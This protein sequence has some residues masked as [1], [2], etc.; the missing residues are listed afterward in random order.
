MNKPAYTLT[1]FGLRQ[2]SQ[3]KLFTLG[4][5]WGRMIVILGALSLTLMLLAPAWAGDGTL[6]PSFSNP[7]V[8]KIPIVRGKV[9]YQ[10]SNGNANGNSL[11]FGYFTS[12]TG[13]NGTFAINS[14]A[15]LPSGGGV[16]ANFNIPVNGQ[17]R[18]VFLTN[19]KS[20]TSNIVLGGSFSLTSGNTTYYNL[21]RLTWDSNNSIYVVDTTFP[22]VFNQVITDAGF[23]VS[24]VNAIAKQGSTGTF[25][26]GGYN[27]QV[28]GDSSNHAYHL[29]H[30]NSSWNWD[31]TYS[32]NNPARA[33]PGGYVNS[34]NL[35]D[36]NYPNQARIFG[37]LPKVGGG[38]D[39]MELTS[40]DLST[41][42]QSLGSDQIDSSIY[43]MALVESSGPWVIW[44]NFKH[45]YGTEIHRVAMLTNDLSDLDNTSYAS[46]NSG[47][48]SGGGAN[49][50]VHHAI[51]QFPSA[52]ILAGTFTS[53]NGTACG[54]L[55]R[56]TSSGTV[57]ST[58][59]PGGSGFDDRTYKVYIPNGGSNINIVGAFR[60]YNNGSDNARHGIVVLDSNG[61]LQGNYA[62]ISA[63]SSTPGTVIAMED[64]SQGDGSLIIGGDFT[65]VGGKWH[66][67]LAKVNQD[68]STDNTY[69]ANVD[70]VVTSLRTSNGNQLVAG[71]FGAA[72]GVGRTSLARLSAD[73]SGALDNSFNPIFVKG[74]GTLPSIHVA[75]ADNSGLIIVGGHFASVNS[76]T[77]TGVVRL[78]S[79]GDLD[80]TFTFT[81]PAGL[82]DIK[83]NAGGNMGGSYPMLGR[84][85]YSGS[86]RGFGLRLLSDGTLDSSF[87]INQSPVANV[88]LFDH[89]VL[90]AGSK[91]DGTLY[92]GGKFTLVNDGSNFTIAR[93]RIARFTPNGT[94]DTSWAPNGADDTIYSVDLQPDGRILVGGLFTQFNSVPRN[95]FARLNSS[96]SVDTSLNPG[97][98]PNGPVALVSWWGNSHVYIGG[99]FSSYNGTSMESRVRII[100]HQVTPATF[101]L[102]LM[103]N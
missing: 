72:N 76:T 63:D 56:I 27:L 44:G 91:H 4:G 102:P 68:G 80:S 84:A 74:N 61:G 81:P 12:I 98:G 19:P 43:G 53:F 96:G 2:S 65:G 30:L 93:G 86:T 103:D 17:I 36:A 14:I 42:T 87:A 33:L 22:Q 24:A 77:R 3:P 29:V 10:D 45:V 75:E 40:T 8:E 32:T 7:K 64:A 97:S 13:S 70:G 92:V 51:P 88:A 25:L 37:T 34:I 47:I 9:D 18:T 60:N 50:A 69:T 54:H 28:N 1:S 62:Q 89:E 31:G 5:F 79:S 11:I 55:V 100:A 49:H 78:L 35:G 16:D 83:V 52:I 85:T 57:D 15:F 73:G 39:W 41:I 58:F 101:L 90:S 38:N 6:D 66:Q 48:I 67:N 59:N 95:A 26:V 46:F 82:S 21:A 23:P 94:L 20:A 99:N 71:H